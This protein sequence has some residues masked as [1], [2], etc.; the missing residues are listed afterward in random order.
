MTLL[1]GVLLDDDFLAALGFDEAE[2]R[3]GLRFTTFESLVF[4]L[5]LRLLV[6]VVS[7]CLMILRMR[8]G[9]AVE[10]R[11]TSSSEEVSDSLMAAALLLMRL[12]EEPLEAERVDLRATI[13]A[14]SSDEEESDAM[15]ENEIY[16]CA[17]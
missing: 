7:L 2:V 14:S 13:G 3:L 17:H 8:R 4:D 10:T 6:V 1:V 11:G 5:G 15:E 16:V 12:M 9:L